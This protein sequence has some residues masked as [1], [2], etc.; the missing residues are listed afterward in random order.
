M[1][2]GHFQSLHALRVQ[3]GFRECDYSSS[4]HHHEIAAKLRAVHVVEEAVPGAADYLQAL[5]TG[6]FGAVAQQCVLDHAR[7]VRRLEQQGRDSLRALQHV[8]KVNC[9]AVLEKN[10]IVCADREYGRLLRE[11]QE[12][13]MSVEYGVADPLFGDAS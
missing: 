13:N 4:V 5:A 12:Y 6:K 2:A 3:P 9:F 8:K 1:I 10:R 7:G 11:R